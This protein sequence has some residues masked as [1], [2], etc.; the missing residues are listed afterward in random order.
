MLSAG[1]MET[2]GW[3]LLT[4]A[5]TLGLA[6]LALRRSSRIASLSLSHA[7]LPVALA[8]GFTCFSLLSLAPALGK[9]EGFWQASR[10]AAW[11]AW[12]LVI[13]AAGSAHPPLWRVLRRLAVASA[14][15]GGAFAAAQCWGLRACGAGPSPCPAGWHGDGNPAATFQVLLSPWILWAVIEERGWQRGLAGAAWL[16][17]GCILA[18]SQSRA[19]WAGAA[20][21][22]ATALLLLL[23]RGLSSLSEIRNRRRVLLFA[24]LPLLAA[25]LL[26]GVA[27]PAEEAPAGS[28]GGWLAALAGAGIPGALCWA[29]IPA[30][31]L[32]TGFR[33]FR[34]QHHP[35][36][37]FPVLLLTAG[38]AGFAAICALDFPG[39]RPGHMAWYAASLAALFS[40]AGAGR[41]GRAASPS[42]AYATLAPPEPGARGP[43]PPGRSPRRRWIPPRPI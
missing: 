43:G 31:A 34:H 27:G 39:G 9:A 36:L 32:F 33:S 18:V 26:R 14:L 37:G 10:I 28:G 42:N 21:M 35:A 23:S 13:L 4:L 40:L 15:L 12:F 19:A 5:A 16:L 29:G 6:W 3:S 22:G 20:M 11:S 41:P 2:L 17:G 30:A 38:L 24:V 25:F 7:R 8:G 1:R